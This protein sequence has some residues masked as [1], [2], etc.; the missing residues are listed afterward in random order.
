MDSVRLGGA[1]RGRDGGCRAPGLLGKAWRLRPW[2]TKE[3]LV[4]NVATWRA[5][6]GGGR[7]HRNAR[8]GDKEELGD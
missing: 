8:D 1:G 2:E 3:E 4:V 7:G 5:G 6:P